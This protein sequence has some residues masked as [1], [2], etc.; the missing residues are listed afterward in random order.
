M[1]R[2]CS[3]LSVVAGFPAFCILRTLNFCGDTGRRGDRATTHV[4]EI[5][6][7]SVYSSRSKIWVKLG[8][9]SIDALLPY[10]YDLADENSGGAKSSLI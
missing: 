10:L 5:N 3:S 6:P 4:I 2:E 7:Q 8:L 9:E 1:E